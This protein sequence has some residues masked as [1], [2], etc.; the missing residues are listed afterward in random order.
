MAKINL[1]ILK[2]LHK[3]FFSQ[4]TCNEKIMKIHI[5]WSY[6]VRTVV[7]SFLDVKQC[8]LMSHIGHVYGAFYLL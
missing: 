5:Y 1:K 2:R 6:V 4:L 8:A 3:Y 7:I